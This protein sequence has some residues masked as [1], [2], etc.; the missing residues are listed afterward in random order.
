MP[1]ENTV[2]KPKGRWPLWIGL[3]VALLGSGGIATV[4]NSASTCASADLVTAAQAERTKTTQAARDV[5]QDAAM[6][7]AKADCE[8]K[9]REAFGRTSNRLQQMEVRVGN[10]EQH[11]AAID[12]RSRMTLLWLTGRR[13][14]IPQEL[15]LPTTQ[16]TGTGAP[17]GPVQPLE[18]Y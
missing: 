18:S 13:P 5:G 7:K 17:M 9:M 6:E 15:L 10:V 4:I 8:T 14:V 2:E 3:I 1:D 16:G 11:T 12:E